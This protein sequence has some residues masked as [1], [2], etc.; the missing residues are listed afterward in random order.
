VQSCLLPASGSIL[1]FSGISAGARKARRQHGTDRNETDRRLAQPSSLP[2]DATPS[3][4]RRSQHPSK[5]PKPPR[6]QLFWSAVEASGAARLL[7]QR[8]QRKC[9]VAAR[10]CPTGAPSCLLLCTVPSTYVGRA[11]HEWCS[12]AAGRAYMWVAMIP[13]C[14]SRIPLCCSASSVCSRLGALLSTCSGVSSSL[15][16]DA[17]SREPGAAAPNAACRPRLLFPFRV[18][19]VSRSMP[20]PTR[21]MA[22]YHLDGVFFAS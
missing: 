15:R 6:P 9:P 21:A 5:T 10:W 13:W 17:A 19:P 3:T 7:S 14:V 1:F 4:G 12:R 2:H 20:K 8:R 22:S 11:M 18:P 16:K